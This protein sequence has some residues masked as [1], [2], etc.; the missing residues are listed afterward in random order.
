MDM[1]NTLHIYEAL[2]DVGVD[3]GKARNVERA[4]E[5]A[6]GQ[7]QQQIERNVLDRVLTKEDGVR[8]ERQILAVEQKVVAVEQK[9]STEINAM[10]RWMVGSIFTAAGLAVAAAKLL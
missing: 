8:L 10:L 6:V 9:L 4:L 2:T 7:A 1:S 5:S 3:P